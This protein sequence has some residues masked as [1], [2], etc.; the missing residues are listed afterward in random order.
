MKKVF[1]LFLL[2]LVNGIFFAETIML[3]AVQ[4]ANGEI[5]IDIA[6]RTAEQL[7]TDLLNEKTTPDWMTEDFLNFMLTDFKNFSSDIS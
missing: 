6:G 7:V 4:N 5:V 3:S 1:F 2:V